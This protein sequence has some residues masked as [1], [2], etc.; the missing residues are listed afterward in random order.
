MGDDSPAAAGG[1][2]KASDCGDGVKVLEEM[3]SSASIASR[4]SVNVLPSSCN[5]LIFV[6]HLCKVLADSMANVQYL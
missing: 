3:D 5:K 2:E 1:G 6:N 4:F